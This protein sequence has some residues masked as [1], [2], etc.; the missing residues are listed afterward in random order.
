MSPKFDSL[1]FKSN[2]QV[3][4]SLIPQSYNMNGNNMEENPF[5][6]AQLILQVL[7]RLLKYFAILQYFMLNIFKFARL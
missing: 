7:L 3:L 6:L 2:E 4:S 1:N 5:F